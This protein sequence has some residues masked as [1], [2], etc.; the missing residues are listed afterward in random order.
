MASRRS[1]AP[2]M[3]TSNASERCRFGTASMIVVAR[4]P[5]TFL[6]RGALSVDRNQTQQVEIAQ[7]FS[8][9]Q[10]SRAQ[11]VVGDGDGQ[12][13]LFA[14]ALVEIA[15]ERAAAGQDDAA[16]ADVG[17]KFRRCAFE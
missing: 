1:W 10:H 14:N 17:G 7:H 3:V 12:A 11:R 6:P 2:R 16:V 5:R 15:Q 9:A 4:A 13:S 8:G